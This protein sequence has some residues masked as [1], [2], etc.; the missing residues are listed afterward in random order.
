MVYRVKNHNR[1]IF[2]KIID[3]VAQF[4]KAAITCDELAFSYTEKDI[5]EAETLVKKE[6]E[7]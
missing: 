4:I 1:Y 3:T 2:S 6:A 5:V 7:E